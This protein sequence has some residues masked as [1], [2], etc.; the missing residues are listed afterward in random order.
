MAAERTRPVR[1][2]LQQGNG[3]ELMHMWR[4]GVEI[5][6]V[7]FA[8][9]E[10]VEPA[11]TCEVQQQK[12]LC[13]D[14]IS[15]HPAAESDCL[16]HGKLQLAEQLGHPTPHREYVKATQASSKSSFWPE[17]HSKICKLHLWPR[18]SGCCLWAQSPAGAPRISRRPPVAC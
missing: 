9:P 4:A 10:T 5:K 17:I 7:A 16:E 8:W 1:D 14:S 3:M 15:A 13:A 6:V 18:H 2:E 12:L 11:H